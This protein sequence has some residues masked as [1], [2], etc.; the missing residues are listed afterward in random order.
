MQEMMSCEMLPFDLPAAKLQVVQ[1][2]DNVDAEWLDRSMLEPVLLQNAD[3]LWL[4]SLRRQGEFGKFEKNYIGSDVILAD[5]E[6]GLIVVLV[7]YHGSTCEK[8]GRLGYLTQKGQFYRY[9][10]QGESGDWTQV[11]WRLLNDELR[12]FI[13]SLAKPTWAKVPGKLQSERNPPTKPTT[14]ASYKVVRLIGGRYYSLYD[15]TVEYVLGE[16][17]KQ[18][19]LPGHGGGYYSFST[20]EMGR[21]FLESCARGIPFDRTVATPELALLECVVSGRIIDYGHKMAS[22]YLCPL[23]VLDVRSVL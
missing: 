4:L 2:S 15:P 3:G 6:F 12:L 10:R 17:L 20:T 13:L 1:A 23:R 8:Y 7:S 14:M 11:P 21:D 19:A 16:R 22:T 18:K 9:Y 5:A